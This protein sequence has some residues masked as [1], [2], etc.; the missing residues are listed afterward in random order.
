MRKMICTALFMGIFSYGDDCQHAQIALLESEIEEANIQLAIADLMNDPG[1]FG[2][3]ASLLALQ[4]QE[5]EFQ[6]GARE[7]ILENCF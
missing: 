2:S 6:N 3:L 1:G 5:Q 7:Y 4:V